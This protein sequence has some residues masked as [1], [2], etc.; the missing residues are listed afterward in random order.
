MVGGQKILRKSC[1]GELPNVIG[2]SFV[3]YGVFRYRL[4]IGCIIWWFRSKIS[5]SYATLLFFSRTPDKGGGVCC[6]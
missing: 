5:F 2:T 1:T 6:S 3:L 4:F